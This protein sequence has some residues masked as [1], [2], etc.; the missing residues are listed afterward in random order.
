MEPLFRAGVMA[1]WVHS[2]SVLYWEVWAAEAEEAAGP[3]AAVAGLVV[4]EALAASVVEAEEAEGRADHGKE[5]MN[6]RTDEQGTDEV[7]SVLRFTSSVHYSL[8]S[9]SAVQI[10]SEQHSKH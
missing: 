4:A 1:E 7:F 2:G 10:N 3:E 6:S 8:F 5:Q 9:C